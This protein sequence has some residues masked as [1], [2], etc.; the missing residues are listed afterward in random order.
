[1]HCQTLRTALTH[2]RQTDI[3]GREL[4]VGMQNFPHLPS[5]MTNVELS[6]FLHKKKLTEID[7]N[8]WEALRISASL[9]LQW[10]LLKGQPV[11]SNSLK[12]T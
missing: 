11:S 10:L 8:M 6:T 2:D 7:P 12:P 3:D 9:L 4:A 5:N 1:M